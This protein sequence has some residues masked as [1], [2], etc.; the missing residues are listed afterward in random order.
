VPATLAAVSAGLIAAAGVAA[1]FRMRR[2]PSDGLGALTTLAIG[3]GALEIGREFVAR[4]KHRR[5]TR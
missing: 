4:A 3:A 5:R 1:A 2:S